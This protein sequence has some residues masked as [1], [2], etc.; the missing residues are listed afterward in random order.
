MFARNAKR[1]AVHASNGDK[2][3]DKSKNTFKIRTKD[4]RPRIFSGGIRKA[5]IWCAIASSRENSDEACGN[6]CGIRFENSKVGTA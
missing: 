1:F 6:A 4:S 2:F 5:G 3:G